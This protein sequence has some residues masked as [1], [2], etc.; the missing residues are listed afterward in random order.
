MSEHIKESKKDLQCPNGYTESVFMES[1][2]KNDDELKKCNHC[3]N[4]Q[5]ECGTMTC[6]K[7]NEV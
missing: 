6:A 2:G 7:F 1:F 4:F 5:Y 3:S